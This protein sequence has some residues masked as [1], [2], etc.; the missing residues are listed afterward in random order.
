MEI[1]VAGAGAGKTTKMADLIL[2]YDIPKGKIIFCIAFTNAAVENIE[3]RIMSKKGHVP[4]NIKISTIHSFLYQELIRPFYYLLFNK[5]YE[6][7]SA[8]NL[9][10]TPQFKNKR[11]KELEDANLLHFSA[12]PQKA[13]WIVHK[14]GGDNK[15]I[16]DTRK[17][18]LSFISNYCA[19]IFVDEA[20]DIDDD[21][22]LILEALD[23]IGIPVYLYGDPKQDVKGHGNYR[24]MINNAQMV[25][26]DSSCHRCPQKHLR[27]SN[28]LACKEE[29]QVAAN[30]NTEGTIDIVFE[31]DIDSI[32]EFIVNGSF[33]LKYISKKTSRFNTH[34]Q[35]SQNAQFDT[36]KH[37]VQRAMQEKWKDNTTEHEI[38]R[39]AFYITEQMFI[40]LGNGLSSYQIIDKW[41]R[42]NAFDKF[43]DKQRYAQMKSALS[44]DRADTGNSPVV[45]SI[46]IIKG[47]EAERCLFILTT[48]LASYLFKQ[49]RTENKTSHLLYVAL[50][51]SSEH[52]TILITQEVESLYTREAINSFFD[53]FLETE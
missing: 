33:G 41:T 28:T 19:A 14:K 21:V 20:Q 48:D 12:I 18:V 23:K 51:R 25:H 37:E 44:L 7:I 50:T 5:H 9:P 43:T 36:L 45:Q 38:F 3:K 30:D 13:K 32:D 34:Q 29:K 10:T 17:N 4:D 27:L 52:L 15:K 53:S 6:R 35:K 47:L 42:N 16:R 1:N 24:F 11:L 46:E 39:A 2:N 22:K 26:Y 31:S 8:I 49:K 40:D